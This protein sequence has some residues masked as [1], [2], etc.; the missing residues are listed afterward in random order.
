MGNISTLSQLSTG[1]V[2]LSNLILVSPQNTVGYQPLNPPSQNGAPVQL[3]PALI[4]HYEGEQTSKFESDITDHFVENNSAIQDQVSLKPIEITTH[5][6]IGELNDVPPAA[7]AIL[8]AA[9]TKLTNISGYLP[10]LSV[11]ALLAY[12]AAFG[13]YQIA[14]NAVNSV[15]STWGSVTGGINGGQSVVGP[16]G[17]Q[18]QPNQNKQ[19]TMYQQ[20]F[21]YWNNRTLFNVQ[22]PWAVFSNMVIKSLIAIQDD[23]T[24]MVTD[25]NITFKQ[26]RFASTQLSGFDSSVTQTRLSAQSSG[27]V[28][29]GTSIPT[30]STSVSTAVSGA[31]PGLGAVG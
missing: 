21:G 7:L 2:S 15:V 22:T 27:V 10:T 26:L 11:T 20:F 5:G 13:A 25:F 19:Q 6:F 14:A 28:N 24:N 4:F 16:N 30:S 23:K 3:P 12:N 31:Y 18:T 1:A 9:T 8:Q 17:I 29:N